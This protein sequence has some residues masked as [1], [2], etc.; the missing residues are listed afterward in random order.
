[1]KILV[2]SVFANDTKRQQYLLELQLRYLRATTP[3][4]EHV[5]C[6]MSRKH[7]NFFDSRT[8]TI[9]RNR[10]FRGIKSNRA[11]TAGLNT[12]INYFRKYVNDFDGF[13]IIDSDAFPINKRWQQILTNRMTQNQREI[14]T[15]IRYENLETRA[16]VSIIYALP[17]AL[18]HIYFEVAHTG[19]DVLGKREEDACLPA[20]E[21]HRRHLM[22]PLLRSNQ[23]NID[24]LFYGIYYNLFYHH[25]CGSR[26]R[27]ATKS[28][29]YWRR[30]RARNS[31]A[32]MTKKLYANPTEF[33]GKLAGWTPNLYAK[34]EAVNFTDPPPQSP[35]TIPRSS[36]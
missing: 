11:H 12:L 5:V 29:K 31:M 9:P 4:F 23:Y 26:T 13:L 16:H 1:M 21:K 35:A 30:L 6:L 3:K 10:K 7:T 25:C 14:A 24:P 2:G 36:Q 19:L 27:I 15:P 28:D 34:V 33:I 22:L 18:P 20:Y 8:K 32:P 17:A